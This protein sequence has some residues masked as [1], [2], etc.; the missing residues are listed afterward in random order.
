MEGRSINVDRRV[1]RPGVPFAF[2]QMLFTFYSRTKW[3]VGAAKYRKEQLEELR[4]GLRDH[5]EKSL[6]EF[7]HD[8]AI[9]AL[10]EF[11]KATAQV[12]SPSSFCVT[13]LYS[14]FLKTDILCEHAEQAEAQ[15]LRQKLIQIVE[16]ISCNMPQLCVTLGGGDDRPITHC[17]LNS[18]LRLSSEQFTSGRE[19]VLHSVRSILASWLK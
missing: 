15:S 13:Y 5:C 3:Q 16:E 12:R 14:I 8:L 19:Q 7:S 2:C 1:C 11:G 9:G 4:V 10:L 18:T 6:R 17:E